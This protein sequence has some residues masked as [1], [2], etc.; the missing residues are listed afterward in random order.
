MGPGKKKTKKNPLTT[1]HY[2][3]IGYVVNRCHHA[4]IGGIRPASMPP[5]AH[6]LAEEGV[7]IFPM[8]LVEGGQVRWEE[9]RRVLTS[10]PFPTRNVEENLAD[11]AAALAANRRGEQAVLGLVHEHGQE[12]V[13]RQMQA[14]LDYS[15]QRMRARLAQLPEGNLEAEEH[16]DDGTKL[17]VNIHN[18]QPRGGPLSTF[19]R[20]A[21]RFQ[22]SID[23]SG[24]APVH[25]GNLN[26]TEAIVQSVVVYVLRVLLNENV[27]LNEG[28]LEPVRIRIP[29]NSILKPDFPPDPWQCPAVVG[30]NV[31]LSQRLTGL[32]LKAFGIAAGS[33][34]TMNN[35]LFGKSS[36]TPDAFGYYE[37]L[38]GGGG[39]GEGFAG[40]SAVQQHMTNTRITDPEI[41]EHRYPVRLRRFEIRR[42]SGGAGQW[43]GGD[44]LR[45]ELEFLAQVELS[46]L[47]QHRNQGPYGMMGGEPGQP[48]RQWLIRADGRIE[49]LAGIAGATLL[50]GDK[51][52]IETP[53]GGGWGTK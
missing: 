23:F 2:P 27:P 46:V 24:S 41:L 6:C 14:V 49:P 36:A 53:G 37:T 22:L 31:E 18:F 25:P 38:G 45:R 40:T 44:G 35:V 16:L 20:A 5:D 50:V 39:A 11:L 32:L 47:T 33:Q 4:E 51:L 29:E 21:N 1:N 13:Q 15:A 26:G 7:V 10:G 30:G 3:P 42:G 28:L 8:K 43:P 9:M 52:V 17:K 34:G 48:G 12:K 19:N